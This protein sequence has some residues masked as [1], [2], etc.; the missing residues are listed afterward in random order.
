MSDRVTLLPIDIADVTILVDNF[1]D[2]LLPGTEMVRRAPLV[3]DWSEREQL[4]AEHGYSPMLTVGSKEFFG[5]SAGVTCHSCCI[6]MSGAT[7]RSC[8]LP[9]SRSICRH[10]VIMILIAKASQSSRS[11]DHHSCSMTWCW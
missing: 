1:V 2:I 5:V 3:W 11:G 7:A 8:F 6:L 10:P 4:I 9:V